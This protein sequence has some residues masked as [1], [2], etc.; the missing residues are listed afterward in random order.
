[1][2]PAHRLGGP[3]FDLVKRALDTSE[4]YEMLR[5]SDTVVVAVSGG[6][7]STC[8]LDV[9]ARAPLALELHVAHVDHGLS[10]A[11]AEVAGEVATAAAG[12]GFEVH[13]I[14][15]P[16]LSGP[17]L[18]ARAREFRLAFLDAIAAQVGAARVA[19]GHTLDD[20]VETLIARL[21]HGAGSAGLAGIRPV[22]GRRVRPLLEA[23]RPET[24]AYCRERGLSFRDDPANADPRFERTAVRHEL[25]PAIERR[26]GEGA[27]RAIAT[28]S[29]RL[30]EDSDAL[31]TLADRLYRDLA[32]G[33][34]V[35]LEL[36]ALR[37]LPPA[38]RRRLLERAVGWVRDRSGG[39]DAAL[40]AIE[41]PL[42]RAR[43]FAVAAG[44][45][46]TVGSDSVVVSPPGQADGRPADHPGEPATP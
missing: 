24:R 25:L 17:N 12:A 21:V 19:T 16:E 11:S 5:R 22:E 6:P 35:S 9:L 45:E 33:E 32:T 4:R 46:I 42:D 27:V 38:L 1:M 7:D 23:R 40:R 44:A 43:R 34:P 39:I 36:G 28:S 10:P 13:V 3:G 26:W 41:R 29:E 15:A 18:Q 30:R 31:E 14:R 37:A 8:L 2:A 20:R